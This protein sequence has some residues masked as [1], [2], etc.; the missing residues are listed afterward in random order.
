[1]KLLM[2]NWRKLL[3]ESYAIKGVEGIYEPAVPQDVLG[4]LEKILVSWEKMDDLSDEERWQRYA[5]DIQRVVETYK[6]K[7]PS[8][9]REEGPYRDRRT[10]EVIEPPE[11]I[12]FEE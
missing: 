4:A 2:E 5:Q 1:M 11:D 6:E 9:W 10:K 3:A 7:K 12:P 8:K